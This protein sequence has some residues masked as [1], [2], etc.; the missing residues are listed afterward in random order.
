MRSLLIQE[1]VYDIFI[2]KVK[3]RMKNLYITNAFDKN[4]TL[5]PLYKENVNGNMMKTI[6][7]AKQKGIEVSELI[8]II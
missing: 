4:G 8:D 5:G 1:S 7:I 6:E 2:E 3:K